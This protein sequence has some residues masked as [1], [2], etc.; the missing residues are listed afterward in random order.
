MAYFSIIKA[1]VT[2]IMADTIANTEKMKY[3]LLVLEQTRVSTF[4][5][6]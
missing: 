4:T 1:S 6:F 3:F 5:T 2:K